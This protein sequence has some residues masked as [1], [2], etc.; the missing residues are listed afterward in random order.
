MAPV[1][2]PEAR[3]LG[4]ANILKKTHCRLSEPIPAVVGAPQNRL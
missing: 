3:R 4:V 1:I 2:K